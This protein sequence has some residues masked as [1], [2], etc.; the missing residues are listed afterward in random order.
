M[1]LTLKYVRLIIQSKRIGTY[2][3]ISIL[4]DSITV[5]MYWSQECMIL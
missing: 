1:T 4:Q 3:K 5:L 2:T